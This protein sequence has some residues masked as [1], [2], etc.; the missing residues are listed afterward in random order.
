MEY[1]SV[2]AINPMPDYMHSINQNLPEAIKPYRG[3]Y[4]VG[5][6]GAFGVEMD[7][8]HPHCRDLSPVQRENWS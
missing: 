7:D 3:I 8:I 4:A 5:F 2:A 1:L 6:F